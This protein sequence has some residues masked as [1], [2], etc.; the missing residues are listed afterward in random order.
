MKSV[1]NIWKKNGNKNKSCAH[2]ARFAEDIN[3]KEANAAHA[4]WIQNPSLLT[5]F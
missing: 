1:G 2:S 5:C 3:G 4:V